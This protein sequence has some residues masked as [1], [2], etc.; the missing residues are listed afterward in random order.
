MKQDKECNGVYSY[1]V[2]FE[3]GAVARKR[4]EKVR[5]GVKEIGFLVKTIET[6]FGLRT[7]GDIKK[8]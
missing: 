2:C 4:K 7:E 1:E 6:W 8:Q 5:C 3:L